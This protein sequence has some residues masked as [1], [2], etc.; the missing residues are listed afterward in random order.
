MSVVKLTKMSGE[1]VKEMGRRGARFR[2]FATHIFCHRVPTKLP[3]TMLCKMVETLLVK[4]RYSLPFYLFFHLSF[5]IS[6]VISFDPS[7]PITLNVVTEK[8]E[9][10]FDVETTLIGVKGMSNIEN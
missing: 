6:F 1:A 8:M 2:G 5:I 9:R 10:K 4:K 7:L 3:A